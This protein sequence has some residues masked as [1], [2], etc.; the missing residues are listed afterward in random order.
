MNFSKQYIEL[1]KNEVIQK[2]RPQYLQFGDFVLWERFES[3]KTKKQTHDLDCIG[4]ISIMGSPEKGKNDIWLPTGDQL[5]EQIV[6]ICKE[7]DLSY[8]IDCESNYLWETRCEIFSYDE[9]RMEAE[10]Q[11]LN[12]L[13]AK[14]SLL[15]KLLEEK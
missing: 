13:I 7:R 5:D 12:P 11:E 1:A 10:A 4:Q 15:I 14:I 8:R 3:S 9:N 6:K 2:L